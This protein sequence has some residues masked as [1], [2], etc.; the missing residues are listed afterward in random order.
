MRAV[1]AS[2]HDLRQVGG[3]RNRVKIPGGRVP[4]ASTP[5]SRARRRCSARRRQ[6]SPA[7]RGV[8]EKVMADVAF[9]LLT[10]AFFALL[11][12]LVKGLERL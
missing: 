6:P 5:D 3:R 9:V 4:N 7:A 12:L 11:G 2:V 8:A 10:V 1:C